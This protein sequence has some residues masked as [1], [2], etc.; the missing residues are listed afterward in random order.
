MSCER[1]EE[2][3]IDVAAGRPPSAAFGAHLAGCTACRARVNEQ[4]HVLEDVD[5]VMGAGLNVAP[6]P[7]LAARVEARLRERDDRSRWR[8]VWVAAMAAVLGAV[9][10]AGWM[11]RRPGGEVPTGPRQATTSPETRPG[12]DQSRVTPSDRPATPRARAVTR[13]RA[14]T[15]RVAVS[16]PRRAAAIATEPL[17]LVPPGQGEALR[18][19]V[20]NLGRGTRPA[21]PLLVAG[22]SVDGAV[23]PPPLLEIPAVTVEPLSDPTVSPERSQR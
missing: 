9:L 18:R 21:P 12:P 14:A 6:S 4:R 16:A 5:R 15:P 8:P 10:L 22:A 23:E 13:P 19:F 20:A 3:T 1:F 7:D 17:V 2:E 11:A